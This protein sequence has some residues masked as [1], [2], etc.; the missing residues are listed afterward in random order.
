ML[1]THQLYIT[2]I[3]PANNTTHTCSKLAYLSNH[4]YL[5]TIRWRLTSK[6][7][8]Y[9]I[10]LHTLN[11]NNSTRNSLH[12]STTALGQ[13][14]YPPRRYKGQSPLK[15]A[16]LKYHRQRCP[17]HLCI[18]SSR[19]QV[20]MGKP[21]RLVQSLP[22]RLYWLSQI[23]MEYNGFS[24]STPAIGSRCRTRFVAMSRVSTR[25]RYRSSSRRTTAS[26]QERV[27]RRSRTRAIGWGTR[28]NVMKSDGRWRIS[29][30]HCAVKEA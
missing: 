20:E 28:R 12:M 4:H 13:R 23:R 24:S 9:N 2:P 1:L 11:S 8:N 21:L 29:I 27:V 26:T 17:H 19:L 25:G 18:R 6:S 14:W 16:H 22:P 5:R 10:I 30:P 3:I 7:I 15:W